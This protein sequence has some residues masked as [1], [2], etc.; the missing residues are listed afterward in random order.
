MTAMRADVDYGSL[1]WGMRT[2]GRLSRMERRH[3]LGV[4]LLD[5]AALI[6]GRLLL[7][8]GRGRRSARAPFSSMA[9]PDT[10]LASAVERVARERQSATMLAHALRTV[11]LAHALAS[12]D[13][14]RFDVELLWCACLLHDVALESPRAGRCFAVRGGEIARETALDA[15]SDR[16]TAEALGDAVSRHAT[17]G[18][19]PGRHPL[20]Y[21]VAGG[22]LVDVL[23][24]RLEDLDAA[25]VDGLIAAQPR[26]GFATALATAWR[27][28]AGAVPGGRAALAE[29]PLCFS[30]AA[31][32]APLP[33]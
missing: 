7:A 31:R 20:P 16:A 17:P 9:V 11:A 18:L 28:E 12:L 10:P 6:R 14:V 26:D 25:F 22:A 5:A 19:D 30:L 24:R 1:A 8:T 23:G 4:G 3:M 13:A 27:A 2:G 32:A 21:L 29:R 15:G 33:R